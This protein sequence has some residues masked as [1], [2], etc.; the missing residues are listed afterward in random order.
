MMKLKSSRDSRDDFPGGDLVQV[1]ALVGLGV[2]LLVVL[3]VYEELP[4]APL[5]EQA[6]QVR[7]EG[8]HVGCRDFV[9]LSSSSSSSVYVR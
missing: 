9:D 1:Q 8:L 2:V 6:H 4:G 3:H 7:L 5:L